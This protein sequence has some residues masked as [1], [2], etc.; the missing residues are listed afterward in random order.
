MG[1]IRFDDWS[2]ATALCR[3]GTLYRVDVAY[4]EIDGGRL[5]GP[6]YLCDLLDVQT[7][8]KDAIVRLNV[9]ILAEL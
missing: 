6:K 7:V 8:E 4:G 3:R 9:S 5:H 2:V 1:G